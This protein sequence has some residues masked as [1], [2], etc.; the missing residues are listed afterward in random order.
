MVI[1][2]IDATRA[3]PAVSQVNDHDRFAWQQRKLMRKQ[4]QLHHSEEAH[5]QMNEHNQDVALFEHHEN[6]ISYE[7]ANAWEEMFLYDADTGVVDEMDEANLMQEEAV[8]SEFTFT[9]RYIDLDEL[10]QIWDNY[11]DDTELKD[12]CEELSNKLQESSDGEE[13]ELINTMIS[14]RQLNTAQMYLLLNQLLADLNAKKRK[15]RFSKQLEE[16]IS[17]YEQQESSYLFEFFSLANNPNTQK[18]LS[19]HNL[20]QLAKLNSSKSNINSV[21]RTIEF[22]ANT[23]DNKFDGIVSLYM[24][25]RAKQLKELSKSILSP[26]EKAQIFELVRLEKYLIV[27]NSVFLNQQRFWQKLIKAKVVANKEQPANPSQALLATTTLCESNLV[28]E[29]TI[30]KLLTQWQLSCD[31]TNSFVGFLKGLVNFMHTLPLALFNDNPKHIEKVVT[32]IKSLLVDKNSELN[33]A[34]KSTQKHL[35]SRLNI[36]L[37][38]KRK[39][40]VKYV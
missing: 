26:E 17:Q 16:V 19:K 25:L 37:N 24:K 14:K 5:R 11:V 30:N 27:V 21:K 1:M 15:Q 6:G 3:H 33:N 36:N 39:G 20:D 13:V 38:P 12:D 2:S 32:N 23:F 10:D 40:L 18:L 34:V 9:S 4:D 28:I 22:V 29:S 35:G 7:R 8:V 31:N